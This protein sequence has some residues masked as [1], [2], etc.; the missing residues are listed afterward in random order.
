MSIQ[1]YLK[2]KYTC[3]NAGFRILC[4]DDFKILKIFNKLSK[5]STIFHRE[6]SQA[7]N[8]SPPSNV[9]MTFLVDKIDMSRFP[10]QS[11]HPPG[12]IQH[13]FEKFKG[14]NPAV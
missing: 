5:F 11:S 4:I 14:I 12:N 8:P 1:I 13:Y 9:H 6:T 3:E 2:Y 7:P 10:K